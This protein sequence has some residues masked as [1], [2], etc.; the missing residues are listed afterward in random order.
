MV[1]VRRNTLLVALLAIVVIFAAA[2]CEKLK[3]S[4]L[5]ANYYF[6]NGNKNFSQNLFRNAISDYE[7]ALVLNP[8][9]GG[10]YRF[11]GESYK[12]LYRPG[13]DTP[14]NAEKAA[15]ALEA[16]QKAY[17]LEPLNKDVIYSL[18]DMYDK[19]RNFDEAEKLYLD[20][21]NLEPG[22]MNNYY[23]VAEFYKRYTADKPEI[24]NKVESMYLRRI[25]TDPESPQGYAYLANY[26]DNIT[27]IPDFDKAM[28]YQQKRTQL[29]PGSAEIL[30]TIGVNRF[31]KAFRLQNML[32]LAE[33]KSLAAESEQYLQKA[34][35]VDPDFAQ[36]YAY[37]KLLYWNVMEKVYPE[38]AARYH[39]EGERYGDKWT[40][41]WKRQAERL[42][43]EKELK[44]ATT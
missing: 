18:G 21:M 19:L 41:L 42:K 24:K 34:I 22:N 16:L 31:S 23:V 2:G 32:P 28:E 43:L 13:A 4:R 25:E 1:R 33:R 8:K 20:I 29:Q 17:E 10:A 6:T 5:R 37:I 3:I 7:K 44:K 39:A 40:E 30:Y 11:L 27:P 38:K 26:Y 14:D 9:M 15:R 36:S 12:N 35:A